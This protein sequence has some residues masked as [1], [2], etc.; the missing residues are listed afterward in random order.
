MSASLQNPSIAAPVY[1]GLALYVDPTNGNDSTAVRGRIDKSYA[2]CAAAQTAAQAGDTIFCLPGAYTE[3]GLGKQNV[4]WYLHQG[5]VFTLA[6][7]AVIF[8]VGSASG[9]SLRVL[10]FGKFLLNDPSAKAFNVT[11]STIGQHPGIVNFDTVGGT[12]YGTA[13]Q[14]GG[15]A[16]LRGNR[17]GSGSNTTVKYLEVSAGTHEI[18]LNHLDQLTT[19]ANSARA[20]LVVDT[21]NVIFMNQPGPEVRVSAREIR[22]FFGSA[23]IILNN[24]TD[25]IIEGA[26]ITPGAGTT[27]GA[28]K[29]AGSGTAKATFIGCIFDDLNI[30]ESIKFAGASNKTVVIMNCHFRAAL[31]N[32]ITADAA[33]TVLSQGG[34]STSNKAEHA[35]VTVSGGW[36]IDSNYK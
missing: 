8:T 11:G 5:A 1:G 19:T 4:D 17:V 6:A 26:Y 28:V 33:Q 13:I 30:T 24:A 15:D 7:S 25:L 21:M 22:A 16:I 3:S 9:E 29:L 14:L 27:D 34:G 32:S 20:C 2:T 35:N 12:S 10:G 36:T 18:I 31:T 23:A